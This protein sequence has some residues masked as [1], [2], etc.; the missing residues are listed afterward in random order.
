M[1]LMVARSA[2]LVVP[3]MGSTM[4]K[5]VKV[6]VQRWTCSK[7]QRRQVVMVMVTA[8]RLTKS[9]LKISAVVIA[10]SVVSVAADPVKEVKVEKKVKVK[11]KMRLAR[12]GR[13]G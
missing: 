4:T 2:I 7:S 11:V 12:V 8:A 10:N 9:G 6:C 5:K 1:H 3:E 13:D